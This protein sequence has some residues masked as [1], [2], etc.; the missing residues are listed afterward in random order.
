MAITGHTKKKKKSV[1]ETETSDY[2]MID[3]LLI[4]LTNL[5]K[6]DQRYI[7]SFS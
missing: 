6:T 7:V 1:N 3:Y 5:M 2:F 4:N